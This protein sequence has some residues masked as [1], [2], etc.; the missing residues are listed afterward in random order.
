MRRATA[1]LSASVLVLGVL[2]LVGCETGR[3][4]KLH[5]RSEAVSDVT[6]VP[7]PNPQYASVDTGSPPVPGSPTAA[8]PNGMQPPNDGEARTSP[9]TEKGIAMAPRRQPVD[10]FVR[11]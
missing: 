4:N 5:S 2:A 8:G 10:K 3:V 1:L 7:H 11:Q 9:G 6:T